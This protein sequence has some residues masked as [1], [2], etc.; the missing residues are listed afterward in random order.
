M[1]L[2]SF[3][4][5]FSP[6]PPLGVSAQYYRPGDIKVT[7]QSGN[8][9]GGAFG[10]Y[11]GAYSLAYGQKVKGDLAL[12]LTGKLISAKIDN[13]SASAYAGDAGLFYRPLKRLT[14]A[15]VAANMGTK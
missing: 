5:P 12:G 6:G 14:L 15:A 9:T 13:V 3:R 8:F 10:G 4:H 2:R 11:Y 7:D 1:R